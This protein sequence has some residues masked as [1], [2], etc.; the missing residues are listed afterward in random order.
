MVDFNHSPKT[1]SVTEVARNFSE[2]LNRV[3]FRGERFFLTRGRKTVAELKPLVV[4]IPLGDLPAIL[5]SAPRLSP[6]DAE[7]FAKD[8]ETAKEEAKRLPIRDTW[9]S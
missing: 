8:I 3:M 6:D 7:A 2:F 4:G 9:G 5:A 1:V